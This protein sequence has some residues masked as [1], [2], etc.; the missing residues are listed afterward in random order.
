MGSA[1]PATRRQTRQKFTAPLVTKLTLT[2]SEPATLKITI[3]R[4]GKV[5]KRYTRAGNGSRAKT[6][7][8]RIKRPAS[9]RARRPAT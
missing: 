2:L 6:L 1:T 4:A 5:R 7:S 3:K 8:F 9:L